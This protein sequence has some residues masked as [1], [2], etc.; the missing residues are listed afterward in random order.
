MNNFGTSQ[1][2]RGK[3]TLNQANANSFFSSRPPPHGF[4]IS[5]RTNECQS[6]I[7]FEERRFRSWTRLAISVE[8]PIFS[9]K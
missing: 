2:V 7:Y 1:A 6:L 4:V 5:C 8:S 9:R 3:P